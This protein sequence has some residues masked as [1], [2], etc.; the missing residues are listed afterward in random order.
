FRPAAVLPESARARP[1]DRTHPARALEHADERGRQVELA[2]VDAMPGTGWV[3][4]VHVVPAFA[5]RWQ[6]QRPQVSGPVVA[7]RRE[8]PAAEQVTQR[9]DAPGDVLK[10]ED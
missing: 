9:V 1:A 10:Q 7:A 2:G 6:G 3:G 4:V 5:Q 8:G